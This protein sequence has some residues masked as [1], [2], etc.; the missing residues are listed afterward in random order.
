MAIA[1][2]VVIQEIVL[3]FIPFTASHLGDINDGLSFFLLLFACLSLAYGAYWSW[4]QSL[5]AGIGWSLIAIACLFGNL[6]N[7]IY[8]INKQPA[9]PFTPN[10]ADVFY[11][12]GYPLFFI[13]TGLIPTERI[14][15]REWGKF[16]LDIA[17]IILSSSLILWR[18]I[19]GPI[20][21]AGAANPGSLALSIAYPVGD[22]TLIW[23]II[24]LAL[25]PTSSQSQKSI[26]LFLGAASLIVIVDT[27]GISPQDPP[28][29]LRYIILSIVYLATALLMMLSGLVQAVQATSTPKTSQ[30][31]LPDWESGLI[32]NIKLCLPYFWMFGAYLVF[33]LLP[34]PQPGFKHAVF[35]GWVALIIFLVI[36]RQVLVLNENVHLSQALTMLNDDLEKRVLERTQELSRANDELRQQM[37]EREHVERV[38][39]EREEKLAHNAMHDALTGLPNR[40]LLMDR[41]AHS[42]RRQKRQKDYFFALLFLDFDRFKTVN[43]SL[44][45]F[46]GDQLLFEIGQRL[47]S[48]VREVDTVSRLGGDEFVILLEDV[49]GIVG[50]CRAADRLLEVLAEPFE[51]ASS[52]IF[53]SASIGVVPSSDTYLQPADILRDADLAMYEAK[54]QGKARYVLFTPDLRTHALDRLVLESDMRQALEQNEF[55]LHYQP[56]MSLETNRFTGFEALV[57]WQHPERGLIPPI[58]FIPIAETSG[59]I[60]PL[61]RWVLLEACRQMR[62]WQVEIPGGAGLSISVNMSP[63]LFTHPDLMKMVDDALSESGLAA[64]CLM[65]EITEGVIVEEA[66]NTN[67][68]L[69]SWRAKGIQVHMDDFGTGYSSLSYLHQFP[70]DTLKIDRAFVK[71]INANGDQGEVVRTILALAKELNINVIAEGVE[72]VEQLDFLKKQGCQSGQ[73]FYISRPLEAEAARNLLLTHENAVISEI[74]PGQSQ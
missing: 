73:G 11:L 38:L 12:G 74:N 66:E 37:N 36:L 4:R 7:L 41:L 21:A 5:R 44:G 56:I 55:R 65:L 25:R 69:N 20:L 51:V 64:S 67:D 2:G 39:R 50:A 9:Q 6:G 42:I 58:E 71:R 15:N 62:A 63:T 27:L 10:L 32:H 23:A 70:I 40:A 14:S 57:R 17:I 28:D 33:V 45:H 16:G 53:L 22:L 43:D 49:S 8:L 24:I 72:T 47:L 61:T 35:S 13:G 48:Y 68:I 26:W 59:M 46:I 18:L 60:V 34:D 31:K 3:G 54:A 52:R 29:S 1:A 30:T 19:F